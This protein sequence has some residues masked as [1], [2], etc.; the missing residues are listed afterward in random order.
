MTKTDNKFFTN[1]PDASLLDRFKQTLKD[2]QFFDVLVGYFQ[3]SGFH[4]LYKDFEQIEKIRVLVGLGIDR[5]AF[6]IIEDAESQMVFDFTH[7]ETR[8]LFAD[9]VVDE[10]DQTPDTSQVEIGIQKFIDFIVSGKIKIKAHPSHKIHAKVYISRFHE[11]DRDFGRVITGSS[12]FSYSGLEGQYEFNVELKDDTDVNFAL[13]QFERL[14][15]EAIDV[16]EDYINSVQTRT[17]LNDK[18]LPY[19]LYLKTIY[20]YFKEDINLD[21]TYEADFPEGFMDLDYQKQATV[22]AY[23]ILQAYNGVF[24]SDVVGLGK[25]Y[26]SALLA[27]Q[28]DGG[29]LVLCPPP[30]KEYW[31]ETFRDFG[32]RKFKVE[33]LGKI[34]QIVETNLEKYQ[35]VFIDEAHRFR[36]QQTQTYAQLAEICAGKKWS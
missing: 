19:M 16:N 36:N 31:E 13:K 35:Y 22:A 14:W 10:I 7:K 30:L 24:L 18:L 11:G 15:K 5:Q 8:D 6:E 29:K 17:W 27:K 33:S 28:L 20:E 1:E 4:E 32:V 21:Q 23:K 3:T 9:T 2:V 34:D 26:I 12:N 25:T